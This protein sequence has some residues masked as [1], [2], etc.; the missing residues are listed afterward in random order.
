MKKIYIKGL[1]VVQKEELET[2]YLSRTNAE[3]YVPINE[4]NPATKKYV[5]DT[6]AGIDIPEIDLSD[7]KPAY[8]WDGSTGEEAV[9]LFQKILDEYFET[10]NI[11][12]AYGFDQGYKH[13]LIRIQY[14][15][16]NKYAVNN[17]FV[18][19][20]VR[21]DTQL[22]LPMFHEFW[23]GFAHEV[24]SKIITNI[25][26]SRKTQHTVLGN[27]NQTTSNQGN[28]YPSYY[29]LPID[30]T[31][32]FTPTSDYNPATKKYVDDIINEI[33]DALAEINNG[34]ESGE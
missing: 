16:V 27:Y 11:P 31:K 8:Y 9:A 10:G 30:N 1:E 24:N 29:A 15:D 32:A 19:E 21:V 14:L 17:F 23:I 22:Q 26:F 6:V 34:G 20:V 25:E 4:Y 18:F 12:E 2:E 13:S 3:I 5:D 33:A 7:Y 28:T